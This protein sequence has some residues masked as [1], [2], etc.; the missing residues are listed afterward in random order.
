MKRLI[1]II[2]SLTALLCSCTQH[3][4]NIGY[5]FG[6]WVMESRTLNGE[7]VPIDGRGIVFKFQNKILLTEYLYENPY[8]QTASY[9]NFKHEDNELILNYLIKYDDDPNHSPI[10]GGTNHQ[11]PTWLGFPYTDQPIVLKFLTLTR[12]EM[13]LQYTD[14]EGNVYVYSLGKV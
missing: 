1:P 6:V 3:D 10:N 8:E 9:G 12:K 7:P 5:L 4:G 14:N 2:I 13:V 11:P